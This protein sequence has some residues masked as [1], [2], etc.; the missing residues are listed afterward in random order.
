M[1]P[2]SILYLILIILIFLI[3]FLSFFFIIP[4]FVGAPYEGIKENPLKEMVKIAKPKKEDKMVDLGSG[5]GRTVIAFAKKGISSVGFEIN[6]FLVLY[7]K[8]KIKKMGLEK[9]AKIHWKNF[10]KVNFEEFSIITTFQYF[11]ISKKLEKKLLRECKK[12]TK[13]I[14]H[15]WKFPSLK[16]KESKNKIYLYKL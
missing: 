4:F 12:G 7:S 9:I 15:Y 11:T 10:W 16:I 13:I 1:V 8:R 6:P 2:N 14:S 5:D 3:I